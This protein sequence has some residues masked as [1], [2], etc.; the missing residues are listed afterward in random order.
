MTSEGA[1]GG[2][3]N[4][5]DVID[6]FNSGTSESLI[7]LKAMGVNA[8]EISGIRAT[9][10]P[11]KI[12]PDVFVDLFEPSGKLSRTLRIS[13][14]LSSNARGFN[15]IDRGKVIQRYKSLWMHLSTDATTGLRLFTGDLPP[16]KPSRNS[17]RM[18]L[19]ELDEAILSEIIS[20]FKTNKI[21]VITDI[22]AGRYPE[23]ADWL[24][25]VDKS[26]QTSKIFD[27]DEAIKF[28]AT[29]VVGISK[30]GSLNL[31]RVTVQRKG[32]DGGKP[33]ANDLQFKFDPNAILKSIK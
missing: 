31:G 3:Q 20:F 18:F 10:A 15:Q 14:K 8:G 17:K 13:V 12:K 7:W 4:E 24:L 21:Q 26:T 27:M 29:G 30:Q 25:T 33:S 6:S 1:K 28:Y 11:P 32:G 16:L 9:K 23:K 2:F 19:D 22:L 5:R